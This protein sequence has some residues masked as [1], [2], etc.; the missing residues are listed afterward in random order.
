MNT[1][2]RHQRKAVFP[3]GRLGVRDFCARAGISYTEFYGRF[4]FDETF[5]QRWDIRMDS[6]GRLNLSA[7]A[8]DAQA[9]IPRETR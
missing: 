2:S 4:R 3:D 9:H 7:A 1:H 6:K 8:A 5:Q